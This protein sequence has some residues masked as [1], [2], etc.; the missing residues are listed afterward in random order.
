MNVW[1]RPGRRAAV[2]PAWRHVG[3]GV[4]R[5][6]SPLRAAMVPVRPNPGGAGVG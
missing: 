2:A 1:R 5:G 3:D 6:G 4:K